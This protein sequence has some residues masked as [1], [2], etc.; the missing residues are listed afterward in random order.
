M[1]DQNKSKNKV[2]HNYNQKHQISSSGKLKDVSDFD[3]KLQKG[4]SV[5]FADLSQVKEYD[6]VSL[7]KMVDD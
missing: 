1:S 2:V 5:N 3:Y 4:K 7:G 6:E